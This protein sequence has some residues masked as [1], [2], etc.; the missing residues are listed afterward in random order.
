MKHGRQELQF[1]I[2]PDGNG[3]ELGISEADA[4]L[5]VSFL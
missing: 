5:C 2:I 4:A 3:P 1:A